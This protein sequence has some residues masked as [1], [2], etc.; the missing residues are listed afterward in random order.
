MAEALKYEGRAKL[1]NNRAVN[2]AAKCTT[3]TRKHRIPDHW[4]T[5]FETI[6]SGTGDC[7]DY[8]ITKYALLRALN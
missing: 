4:A 8:A 5:P 1:G 6:G 3:D 7:E 2:L